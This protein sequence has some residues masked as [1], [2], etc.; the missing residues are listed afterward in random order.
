M[1]AA[2]RIAALFIESSSFPDLR[3]ERAGSS[4]YGGSDFTAG[5]FL[6]Y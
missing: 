5:G 4:I 6:L 2:N 1:A 3:I